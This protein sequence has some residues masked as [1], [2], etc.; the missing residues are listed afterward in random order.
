[1]IKIL[2]PR[3]VNKDCKSLFRT[4]HVGY[5]FKN[6]IEECNVPYSCE[7]CGEITLGNILS[8]GHKCNMCNNKLKR[9][10]KLVKLSF[11][12]DLIVDNDKP[13]IIYSQPKLRI[14]VC[15]IGIDRLYYI[16]DKKYKCP[17]C[18]KRELEFFNFDNW[19]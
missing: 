11:N 3:C 10:G 8:R 19:D 18:M 14:F 6:E 7:V 12:D 1:M 17:L 13:Q 5:E 16:E 2:H 4:L 15:E 9:Y